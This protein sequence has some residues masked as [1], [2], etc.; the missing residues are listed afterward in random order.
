MRATI[1]ENKIRIEN[2]NNGREV[3]KKHSLEIVKVVKGREHGLQQTMNSSRLYDSSPSR[4]F[5]ILYLEFE[6][7]NC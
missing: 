4:L 7:T 2:A 1:M 3:K 6:V 5:K